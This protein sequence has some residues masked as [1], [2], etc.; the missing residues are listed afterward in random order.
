MHGGSRR[1]SRALGQY[2][3]LSPDSPRC[4]SRLSVLHLH[5]LNDRVG[6]VRPECGGSDRLDETA[7]L[8]WKLLGAGSDPRPLG[9]KSPAV[10]VQPGDGP[11]ESMG[12]RGA[13]LR[14]HRLL[15][16]QCPGHARHGSSIIR[17]PWDRAKPSIGDD[18]AICFRLLRDEPGAEGHRCQITFCARSKYQ[19]ILIAVP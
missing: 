17:C 11:L 9:R 13:P 12:T 10:P 7:L 5:V 1:E 3:P 19:L 2:G 18:R 15:V 16:R 4:T 6:D 8:A 14:G